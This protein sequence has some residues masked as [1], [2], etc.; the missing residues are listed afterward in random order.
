MKIGPI[1]VNSAVLLISCVIGLVLCEVGVRFALT[2]SDY[3]S[4][5]MVSDEVLGAVPSRHTRAG[6]YDSW[7]FRNRHVPD[8]SDESSASTW[9]TTSRMRSRSH[10]D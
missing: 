3:L 4:V 1:L 8:S 7:G 9:V 6:G 10:T 5:E 2:A